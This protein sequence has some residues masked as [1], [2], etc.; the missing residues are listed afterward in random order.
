MCGLFAF[1]RKVLGNNGKQKLSDVLPFV[2]RD[3]SYLL[4]ESP[5]KYN[6]R[7]KWFGIVAKT[8]DVRLKT[9]LLEPSI[10]GC[11][12]TGNRHNWNIL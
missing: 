12:S 7:T 6:G 3:I 1:K 10:Y 11:P 5:K 2:E 4:C 8:A 9:D